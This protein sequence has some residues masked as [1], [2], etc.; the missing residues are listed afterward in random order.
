MGGTAE[1]R[2][3]AT[4]IIPILNEREAIAG[5]LRGLVERGFHERH[6][7]IVVDDGS[8]DGSGEVVATFAGVRL[9]RHGTNR[10]YGAALKTGIR[11]ARTEKLVFLDGDGQHSPEGIEEVVRLLDTYPLVIGERGPDSRQERSRLL[12]KRL[13]RILGEYLLGQKLPDFNSGFRGFRKRALLPILGILPSGFSFSTTSTL[14]FIKLGYECAAIPIRVSP[15]V[16]RPSNV[17]FFRDGLKTALL[18]LRI[19]MLFNPLKIFCPASFLFGAAGAGWGIAGAIL[20]RRIPNSAVL[21]VVLGMFLFFI[22][23]LADQIS[24]LHFR[25]QEASDATR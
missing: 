5:T 1:A 23:L 17:R 6:E 8:T 2:D 14:A 9:V 16:G 4:I 10:G 20:A 18:V 25:S 12:G 11:Q 3:A 24:L 15:R 13:V 7:I 22:G 21:T 19:V